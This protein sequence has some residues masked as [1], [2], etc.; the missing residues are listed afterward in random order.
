MVRGTTLGFVGQTPPQQVPFTNGVLANGIFTVSLGRAQR[1]LRNTASTGLRELRVERDSRPA[2]TG[3]RH[4]LCVPRRNLL[5]RQSDASE[6]ADRARIRRRR[7]A[8]QCQRSGGDRLYP[9]VAFTVQPDAAL[10]S[11]INIRLIRNRC[12]RQSGERVRLAALYCATDTGRMPQ[13]FARR[14]NRASPSTAKAPS[15]NRCW[16]RRSGTSPHY[17]VPAQP[18]IDGV[19]RGILAALG[20]RA[21]RSHRLQPLFRRRRQRQQPLWRKRDL[22]LCPGSNAI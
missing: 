15:S 2:R 21:A 7:T 16:S 3:Q 6:F 1:Q 4:E 9:I 13:T 8:G 19:V 17:R 14:C 18:I 5:L 12:R 10:Q 22:R 20:V 11:N